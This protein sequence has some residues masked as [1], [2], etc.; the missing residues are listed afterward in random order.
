[1]NKE[2]I[3]KR[4]IQY[5]YIAVGVILLDIGFYF[6]I[7]PARL[8]L[9]G[10][11]GVS[12]ILEPFYSKLGSWFTDSIFLFIANGV[13]LIIGGILLG[14]DFF[15]KTIFSSVFSPLII[16]LFEQTCDPNFFLKEVSESGYYIIALVCSSILSGLGLGLALKHNGS[17]GGLDVVQKIMSKYLHIPYS[18]TMYL[19]DWVIVFISGFSFI[20]RFSY[21]IEMV[22]Y[23][24]L[25]VLAISQITDAI[26]LNARNRRTAYII[27]EKPEEIKNLIYELT[28]RGV[29]F[30]DASGG[31]TGAHKTMVICTMEKNEAYKITEALKGIDPHAFCYVSAT[32]EIVGEYL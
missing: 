24:V 20:G 3:K 13:V 31:Y 16:L 6:F 12:V 1:M 8:V 29:T 17:T 27:T 30:V 23:G 25:G 2:Y 32:K 22:I 15:L 11:M 9:G 19:T 7:S 10:M 4:L 18:K 14:K 26:A 21:N 5:I 28:D